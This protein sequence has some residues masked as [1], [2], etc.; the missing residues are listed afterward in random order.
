[1]TADE[2]MNRY[3]TPNAVGDF[4]ALSDDERMKI[5]EYFGSP[6]S[7]CGGYGRWCCYDPPRD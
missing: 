6:C 4:K 1:M 3:I 7:R 2:W 5:M